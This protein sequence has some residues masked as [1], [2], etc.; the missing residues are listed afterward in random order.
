VSEEVELLVDDGYTKHRGPATAVLV[1]GETW[2]IARP[3]IISV[4]QIRRGAA[5]LVVFV[6]TVNTCRSPL[7]AALFKKRLADRLECTI[8]Q[9]PAHGWQV[10]SAGVSAAEDLPAASEAVQV[11]HDYGANLSDHRSQFLTRELALQADYLIAMTRGHLYSLRNYYPEVA[12]SPRLLS[13][14][15][16]DI[17]DPIGQPRDVYVA[18][19]QAIWRNLDR[20]LTEITP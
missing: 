17:A 7:A 10:V 5:R 13:P 14:E 9:L 16:E 11:A 1:A 15:G 2:Q 6:C 18:C 8:D 4:E 19:G 3:G 12:T 20:L